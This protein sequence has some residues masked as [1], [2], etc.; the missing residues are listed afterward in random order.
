MPITQDPEIGWACHSTLAS[1]LISLAFECPTMRRTART[2]AGTA[3]APQRRGPL[4]G[5]IRPDRVA[6]TSPRPGR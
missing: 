4:R 5:Q 6:S 2:H 1:P 3:S